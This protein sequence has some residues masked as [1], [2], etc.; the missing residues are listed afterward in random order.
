MSSKVNCIY[1]YTHIDL[2]IYIYIYIYISIYIYIYPCVCI[3]MCMMHSRIPNVGNKRLKYSTATN[4]TSNINNRRTSP[5]NNDRTTISDNNCSAMLTDVTNKKKYSYPT[6]YHRRFTSNNNNASS[7]A[8]ISTSTSTTNTNINTNTNTNTNTVYTSLSSKRPSYK[9]KL[10][11]GDATS[12]ELVKNRQRKILNDINRLNYAISE[13]NKTISQLQNIELIQLSKDTTEMND[14]I[15]SISRDINLCDDEIQ[16]IDDEI[17]KLEQKD[18]MFITN[19]TLRHKIECQDLFNVLDLRLIDKK[20]SLKTEM[21]QILDDFKP[22]TDLVND[23]KRYNEQINL[24]RCELNKLKVENGNKLR[25]KEKDELVPNLEKFKSERDTKLNNLL[26]QNV[27]LKSTLDEIAL[28]REKF[29][30]DIDDLNLEIA[31]HKDRID[32]LEKEISQLTINTT[33]PL[34]IRSQELKN[35]LDNSNSEIDEIQIKYRII[36][37]QYTLQ[38]NKLT[39]E[40]KRNKALSDAISKT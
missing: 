10:T 25:S 37:D 18:K 22:S 28:E 34:I 7:T 11:F 33:P 17:I 3:C 23:I 15:H 6:S 13:I 14:E 31:G 12:I 27:K 5:I 19:E 40:K 8:T 16:S 36:K 2:Y 9:N 4:D 26:T 39:H 21:E 1:I 30:K 29:Q 35:Q 32:T 20:T 38:L 24:Y